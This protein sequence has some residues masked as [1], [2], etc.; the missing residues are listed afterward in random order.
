MTPQ[1]HP[2]APGAASAPPA[3]PCVT[4]AADRFDRPLALGQ[5]WRVYLSAG[6]LLRQFPGRDTQAAFDAAERAWKGAV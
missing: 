4:A 1:A 5:A 6:E 3:A 2:A